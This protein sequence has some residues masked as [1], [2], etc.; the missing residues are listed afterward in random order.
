MA[1]LFSDFVNMC[2]SVAT[3]LQQLT[4]QISQLQ[5]EQATD[6]QQITQL[7]TQAVTLGQQIANLTSQL[8]LANEEI[9]S[10]TASD[11]DVASQLALANIQITNLTA[12]LATANQQIATVQ[13]QLAASIG[14]QTSL[15]NAVQMVTLTSHNCSN[16]SSYNKTTFPTLFT[17]IT[18]QNAGATVAVTIDS[19]VQDDSQNPA[20]PMNISKLSVHNLMPPSWTGRV[21]N[22]M[23]AWWGTANHPP[24]GFS[25]LNATDVARIMD[26]SASRGFDLVCLDW[27]GI[28]QSGA[29]NDAVMDL[30]VQ[31]CARTKQ[32]FCLMIDQQYLKDGGYTAATYQAGL[33]AALNHFA[34]KYFTNPSY[35][36][37][38]GRPIVMLWGV[39]GLVGTNVDWVALKTQIQGNPLIIQYQSSGF[40]IPGSDGAFSWVD[41]S[42]ETAAVPSGASYL[43][44][45]IFPAISAHQDKI[46]ISSVCPGFNGT[47]T[48]STAWSD[49]KFLDRRAGQTW[50]DW[51][52]VN[53]NFVTSGKKLDYILVVTWDDF[54]EGTT[55]QGGIANNI[56]FTNVSISAR[57]LTWAVTGNENTVKTYNVYWTTDGFRMNKVAYV[58]TNAAKSID[59]TPFE[60]PLGA[61][62]YVYAQGQP[63]IQCHLSTGVVYNG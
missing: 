9:T 63:C 43:T 22:C 49:G 48:H 40:T 24:I 14:S 54:Q 46:C 21:I 53:A 35:E 18:H 32:N 50:L 7:N 36:L 39:T 59:L 11:K 60:I 30:M 33:V 42:V 2:N 51:W 34:T 41:P 15:N 1:I 13:A 37:V 38:S 12:Q 10:L 19:T 45:S 27:Y 4:D 28:T 62:V 17:G 56:V 31:N 5:T 57:V 61:M 52:A 20:A 23:Q 29:G 47:L 6:Q 16:S 55:I 3:Q 25:N 58:G 44:N 8:N 26:D